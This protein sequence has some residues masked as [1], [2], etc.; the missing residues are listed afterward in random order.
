MTATQYCKN[1]AA[2]AQATAYY[3]HETDTL[4]IKYKGKTYS[5]DEFAK[6]FPRPLQV[7]HLPPKNKG[8]NSDKT[9]EWMK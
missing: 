1:I 7:T 8:E 5:H 2:H 9:K 4:E 6:K 3:H